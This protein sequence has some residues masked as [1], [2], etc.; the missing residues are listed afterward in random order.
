MA[1]RNGIFEIALCNNTRMGVRLRNIVMLYTNTDSNL[2][3]NR[4]KA[5]IVLNSGHSNTYTTPQREYE[6]LYE[7]WIDINGE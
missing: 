1:V 2:S 5:T 3:D 4:V 7:A 6:A